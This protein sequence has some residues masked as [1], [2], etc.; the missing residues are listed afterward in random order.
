MATTLGL[1]ASIRAGLQDTGTSMT[2]EACTLDA[3]RKKASIAAPAKTFVDPT[4]AVHVYVGTDAGSAVEVT[5]GF[6]FY[7]AGGHVVFDAAITAGNNVYVSGKYLPWAAVGECRSW[8][9]EVTGDAKDVTTINS[10]ADGWKR[11]KNILRDASIN[12][13]GFLDDN[14]LNYLDP[15][16]MGI[17]CY[18]DISYAGLFQW[19]ALGFMVSHGASSSYDDMV[20]NERNIS[21]TGPV[22]FG[23]I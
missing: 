13:G 17:L 22:W 21:T 5:T 10:S 11:Y 8:R 9:L 23:A 20:T 12:L 15:N 4:T 1:V 6:L 3:T 14:L 19:Q 16:A 7:P 18:V 2:K